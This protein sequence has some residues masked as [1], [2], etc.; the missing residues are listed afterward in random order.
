M[1]RQLR[2]D[3]IPDILEHLLVAKEVCDADQHCAKRHWQ[4]VGSP[5]EQFP[6]ACGRTDV[7]RA[8]CG[9]NTSI[10]CPGPI[11]Q[12][13]QAGG[14]EEPGGETSLRRAARRWN[15]ALAADFER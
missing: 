9:R 2:N 1:L 12:R 8:K 15:D 6:G 14:P 10:E 11:E 4:Q 5:C 3:H 13:V 7:E